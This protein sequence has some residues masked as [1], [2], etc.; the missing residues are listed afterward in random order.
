[1]TEPRATEATPPAEDPKGEFRLGSRL[2]SL[3]K[4]AT[5]VLAVLYVLG[6]LSLLN[7]LRGGGVSTAE[8]FR[9]IP[10]DHHLSRG[11]G[12]LLSR[13]G[14][15][16]A[17]LLV[18]AALVFQALAERQRAVYGGERAE[19]QGRLR[20]WVAD[21]PASSI[22]IVGLAYAALLVWRPI[23]V[24][25]QL[26]SM[27]VVLLTLSAVTY[28]ARGASPDVSTRVIVFAL[29]ISAGFIVR[30]FVFPAPLPLAAVTPQNAPE[31]RGQ[32]IDIVDNSWYVAPRHG[33]IE[34]V[35]DRAVVTGRITSRE[36]PDDWNRKSLPQ[37]LG[38]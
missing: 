35:G 14:L 31:V 4:N 24:G 27:T 28:F 16:L 10:I 1:M 8:A 2:E 21:H 34:S 29:G 22:A 38:D 25:Q 17:V 32:F 18:A 5:L 30:G 15:L 6:S 11:L 7:D 26:V 12:I 36:R 37:L 33:L 9:L 20:R 13:T 19:K 23:L 3:A